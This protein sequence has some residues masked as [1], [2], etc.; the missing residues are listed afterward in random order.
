MVWTKS[1][2]WRLWDFGAKFAGQFQ[3][4]FEARGVGGV[5]LGLLDVGGEQDSMEAVGVAIAA[6][7]HDRGIAARGEADQ[8]SLRRTPTHDDAVLVE[9]VDQLV[10]DHVGSEPEREFSQLGKLARVGHILEGG[11]VEQGFGGCVDDLDLVGF[12]EELLGDAGG[13]RA[14]R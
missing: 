4:G 14:C 6:A 7:E 2:P 13:G 10:I 12:L 5:D 3:V 8:D 11:A 1:W 9:V